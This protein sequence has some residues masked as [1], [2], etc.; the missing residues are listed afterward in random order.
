ME[1]SSLLAPNASIAQKCC[2]QRCSLFW[3]VFTVLRTAV[4]ADFAYSMDGMLFWNWT[5]NVVTSNG[6]S[7]TRTIMVRGDVQT[8]VIDLSSSNCGYPPT[9]CT[10]GLS[11]VSR[12]LS[13]SFNDTM[14]GNTSLDLP[15]GWFVRN[16][17]IRRVTWTLLIV[18]AKIP[19]ERML[20]AMIFPRRIATCSNQK[21]CSRNAAASL[22]AWIFDSTDNCWCVCVAHL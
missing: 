8:S 16:R 10:E 6:G 3:L 1:T 21:Q 13:H 20:C 9:E 14:S 12:E 2:R 11:W 4:N 17:W 5:M 18:A 22:A 19:V 7:W 15:C